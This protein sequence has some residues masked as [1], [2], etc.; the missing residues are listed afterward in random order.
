MAH[1]GVLRVLEQAHIEPDLIA[2]TS[3]AGLIGALY[4]A[5]L[6]LGR[7]RRTLTPDGR[8]DRLRHFADL[9][10]SSRGFLKGTRV[11]ERMAAALG[12]C[13]R[14]EDLTIPLGV[15]AVDLRTGREVAL[16]E[17][18][19]L[20]AL[21]ATISV[22]GVLVPVERPDMTLVDGGI[23]NN[24]PADLARTMGADVILAVDV[25]PDFTRN[26]PGQPPLQAPL[27]PA[28]VPSTLQAHQHVQLVMVS[29]VTA[30][31]L[32]EAAPDL[33][34]RPDVPAEV[35]MLTGFDLADQAVAA[36]AEAMRA[37]LPE[38]RSL[39]Q[40]SGKS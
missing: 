39:L 25:M 18:D 27:K 38:L 3:M 6:P 10:I 9:T 21:R 5:E 8:M 23:L 37:A 29:A 34:L 14:F 35:G 32:R 30:A 1:L 22:P 24:V 19:L 40:T 15:V 2:G 12:K 33:V 7:I 31:R 36:G 17:G 16:T 28:G 11:M 26:T 4:A 13:L 20:E